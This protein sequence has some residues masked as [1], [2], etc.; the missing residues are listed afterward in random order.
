MVRV[1]RTSKGGALRGFT[2]WNPLLA[3]LILACF[4][5]TAPGALAQTR[6]EPPSPPG[7]ALG[8][9]VRQPFTTP[10]AATAEGGIA[11]VPGWN[12]ISLPAEPDNIDPASVL[13][14][15]SGQLAVAWAYDACSADPWRRHAPAAPAGENSLQSIDH[16]IGL[17]VEAAAP[18]TLAVS[19]SLPAETTIQLC[20]GWNLIGAPLGEP[21]P[22]ASALA[23]IAGKYTLLFGYDATDPADPWEVFSVSVP[24]WAND[25]R[26]LQPGRGYWLYATEDATLVFGEAGEGLDVNLTSPADTASVTAPTDVVGSVSGADLQEWTLAVREKGEPA[27][28]VFASGT[29]TVPAGGVLGRFDPT[30]LRNGLYEILLTATDGEGESVT[31]SLDVVVEGGMKIGAFTLPFLDLEVPL[32]GLP[33]RVVRT[34]DSRDKREGD[35]GVG[36][37]LTVSDVQLRESEAP[38]DT[39]QGT[40]SGGLFPTY[41]IQPRRPH[42][43]AVAVP[44]GE[45]LRFAAKAMP[46]CQPL[47][48]QQVVNIRFDPLPGTFGT[49]EP[50]DQ[51]T[52]ALVVGGFPGPVQLWDQ[53]GT[54]LVDPEVYRLTLRD[55]RS[56]L[57]HQ[58]DGL[59]SIK[60]RNGNVL[61]FR[62]DGISHSNG[63]GVR[64]DRD[65]EGR[66]TRITDPRNNATEYFYDA[67]GDL[68]RVKDAEDLSTRFV[69]TGDH[70]LRTIIGPDGEPLAAAEYEPDGRL[71]RRC[72]AEGQCDRTIHELSDR[73]ETRT[74]AS[75]R[76]VIYTYD[77][78]GNVLTATDGLNNTWSFEYDALG[79]VTKQTDPTGAVTTSTYDAHG[80]RL[81]V[82]DPHPEGALPDDYTTRYTYGAGD[83]LASMTL[84]TG[85]R[86]EYGYDDAGNLNEIRDEAGR[87]RMSQKY[88]AGGFLEE[89]GDAF[90]SFRYQDPAPS[91]E[92]RTIHEPLG[93]PV[94]VTY[95]TAGNLTAMTDADGVSSTYTYDRRGRELSARHS[96]GPGHD[97]EYGYTDDWTAIT[98]PTMGRV[99]RDLDANGRLTAWHMASGQGIAYQYD[100]A[101][102][103]LQ[104]KTPLLAATTSEYDEAGRLRTLTAPDG[105][106]T[107]Y[108]YDKA[109]RV[110]EQKDALGNT[111]QLEYGADG[112][113][114]KT[115]DPNGGAWEHSRTLTSAST[116]DPLGRTSTV[117]LSPEGVPVRV[118]HPDGA[119]VEVSYLENAPLLDTEDYPTRVRDEGGHVRDFTYDAVGRLA[120]AEDLSGAAWSYSYGDRGLSAIEDPAGEAVVSFTYDIL[121][122]PETQTYG[123]GGAIR[124]D[125]G[126]NNQPSKI[127]RASGATVALSYDASG[128]LT[129]RTTAPGETASFTWNAEDSL[130]RIEN[131][132]GTTT[133][134]YDTAGS[135]EEIAT[136]N[137]G[138]VRYERDLLGRV[139]AVTVRS[140]P[141]AVPYVTR[142]AYDKAGNLTTVTDPL[143]GVTTLEYD[144]VNR[145][146][147]RTLPNG[148]VTALQYNDRDQLT[149][150]EHRDAAGQVLAS[151]AYQRSGV[152]EPARIT[153]EDGSYVVL[154][155]DGALRLT[156]E[157]WHDPAGVLLDQTAYTYDAAGNRQ[158]VETAAGTATYTYQSGYRLTGVSGPGGSETY[159]YDADGRVQ[160][161]ARG[162]RSLTFG[163]DALDRLRSVGGD[164]AMSFSWDAE[165][166]RV[167]ATSAAGERRY[168]IAPMPG[169]GLESPHLVTDGAG[170]MAA[171]YV[172]AG[173]LPLLRFGPEGPVY[174]LTDGMGSV[175]G[176]TDGAG[177]VAAELSYDAF[178]NLRS[179]EG[180]QGEVPAAVGGD[181][182]F[183]GAWLDAE[184]GL[185]NLRAREYDP[186]VGR[187]LSRDPVEPALEN[188]ET[189]HPYQFAAANP[190]LYS[191]PTGGFSIM[192]VN[193]E[194][195]VN[196]ILNGIKTA[197]FKEMREELIERVG[198][199]LTD[200]LIDAIS[201]ALPMNE[202][203]LLGNTLGIHED[204][205]GGKFE[206]EIKDF[207]CAALG[208]GAGNALWF[209]PVIS[210]FTGKAVGNGANCLHD[211]D[212]GESALR[213]K[214]GNK[215][216]DFLFKQG[217]P[218]DERKK[219][220]V[221]GDIKLGVN[222]FY[223]SYLRKRNGQWSAMWKH[224][225]GYQYPPHAVLFVALRKGQDYQ[226]KRLLS[227]GRKR[228]VFLIIFS[229]ESG[230]A[231]IR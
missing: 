63:I 109:G 70:Y 54:I 71:S 114:K 135:L 64:F 164:T 219:G 82:T 51:G 226:W 176:L 223:N 193:V 93:Q 218:V 39:W 144:V 180:P 191:D 88:G 92:P 186:R 52:E 59:Q 73:R 50:V 22:V 160:S 188:P 210:E 130:E 49:L 129:G 213:F 154:D 57:I 184:L 69:Y 60:D 117:H 156:R 4:L 189:V 179:S 231:A 8:P 81:S 141:A 204:V 133:Y 106:E 169:S 182:R 74:D 217:R 12:L 178:G 165:G 145:L 192:S 168:L 196:S 153:R 68:E 90:G 139:T 149:S 209:A 65:S 2:P 27:A 126:T 110:T 58:E 187:F 94:S 62:E 18:A 28:R 17:W 228:K 55:G 167:G 158:T 183:H 95:D 147:K 86:L 33:I 31:V 151:F 136:A 225:W 32:L 229:F 89:E 190:H 132:T 83:H 118:V 216:P 143:D 35:F 212:S 78:K 137:G 159:G 125:Y 100:P 148:V 13:S 46:E 76:R 66:I 170:N 36:W 222:S 26:R 161:I 61:T 215:E 172:Y 202:V 38:G 198:E 103:V 206:N 203:S 131:G 6:Q 102:R 105:G 42:V 174:Y 181:F 185:Y 121:G 84:P 138:S 230:A 107:T 24:D 80:N 19:G 142:Y 85:A 104:Q 124:F 98:T 44:S 115:T 15:I 9:A 16:R 199:A 77:G 157:A 211:R 30:Q 150:I 166:R 194:M 152:G 200:I 205:L 11:L 53:E 40:T 163:Y 123:D 3:Q 101:G 112:R 146:K 21:R 201:K 111:V 108:T 72:D 48:P 134:G 41:C 1:C 214:K 140:A 155:Y 7:Q 122:N 91:G 175:V 67:N 207:F 221:I 5:V 75:G 173:P 127:T 195:S 97:Y 23:S 220:L 99:Q 29:A 119:S 20:Q 25:L 116:R 128:R 162:G 171:G 113:L 56:F 45:V 177:A 37:S 43:V 208:R 224:A 96:A 87:L 120:T 79:N 197:A 47:V 14:S 34:Y 10:A 227:E